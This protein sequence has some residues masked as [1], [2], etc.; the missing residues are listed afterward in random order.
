MMICTLVR[1]RQLSCHRPRAVQTVLGDRKG[2]VPLYAPRSESVVSPRRG[3][4][5]TGGGSFRPER[6]PSY[7]SR[8]IMPTSLTSY[9]QQ[10][11][12]LTQR[13]DVREESY[14][15]ALKTLLEA[16]GTAQG[17]TI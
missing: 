4:C 14:Y 5:G 12:A 3:A 9:L 6:S 13:G 10:I 1:S 11:T 16:I 7:Q 2:S 8:C 15:P 17:R